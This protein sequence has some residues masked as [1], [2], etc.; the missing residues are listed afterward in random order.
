MTMLG[1]HLMNFLKQFDDEMILKK[2]HVALIIDNAPSHKII[3]TKNVKVFFLPPNST[4]VLQP[5][6]AG[7]IRSF[8]ALLNKLNSLHRLL[9]IN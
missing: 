1:Q 5:L 8:K 2:R 4:G 6:D 3:N 9:T 7:I